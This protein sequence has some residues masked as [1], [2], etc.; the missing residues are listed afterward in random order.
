MLAKLTCV[1]P[2][3]VSSEVKEVATE[4]KDWV[5]LRLTK[6]A[7]QCLKIFAAQHN[8]NMSDAL[9]YIVEKANEIKRGAK[10]NG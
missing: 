1:L 6:E 9:I 5:S 8:M 3:S 4:T 7:R 10:E 2:Y